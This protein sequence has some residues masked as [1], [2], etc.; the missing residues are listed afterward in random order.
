MFPPLGLCT[1]YALRLALLSQSVCTAYS[2]YSF[3]SLFKRCLVTEAAVGVTLFGPP[4]TG[5]ASF[6]LWHLP[7]NILDQRLANWSQAESSLCSVVLDGLSAKNGF[8]V[9]KRLLKNKKKHMT[10]H[11]EYTA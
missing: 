9:F 3:K 4:P 10:V 1:S 8:Y 11:Q 6:S 7:P 2:L 5:L